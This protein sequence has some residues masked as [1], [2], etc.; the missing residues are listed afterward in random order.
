M[1]WQG[2]VS[3]LVVVFVFFILPL[4]LAALIVIR[5]A[6]LQAKK[7]CMT[8]VRTPSIRRDPAIYR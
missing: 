1:E 4:L 3:T 5:D 7:A 8:G 2:L 6:R